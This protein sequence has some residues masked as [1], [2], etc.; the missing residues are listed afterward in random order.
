M[1]KKHWAIGFIISIL[2][3]GAAFWG[4]QPVRLMEVLEG[5]D[6][7]YLAPMTGLLF[8][9]L[10]TRTR[11][12]Q[13]LLNERVPYW[14]TFESLNEGY[15]LNMVL[16]LRMGELARAYLVT[17]ETNLH[18][19]W[20]TATVVLERIIDIIVC[21][22]GLLVVL[23]FVIQVDWAWNVVFSVAAG[24][25]IGIFVL[26]LLHRKQ[27]TLNDVLERI[28]FIR[29]LQ[30]SR[31]IDEFFSGLV[32]EDRI[33]RI[34]R[35]GLWSF[36]AWVT[37]WM[38][39]MLGLRMFQ[40]EGSLIVALF[41]SGVVAFGAA[42][43]SLPGAVGVFELSTVAGLLVFNYPQEAALSVAVVIHLHQLIITGIIGA[44]AL[45][46]EGETIAG[47]G[48]KLRMLAQIKA[49]SES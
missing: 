15:L 14:R 22:L 44:A 35:A 9:G 17:R 6:Y 37:S 21:L 13:I 4:V 3:L 7:L 8:L 19:G 33:K 47:L 2:A 34:L 1:K 38:T 31:M 23:P 45:S 10:A 41:V 12:W 36:L 26:Y 43:P 11:S 29:N 24:L 20:T 27:S 32:G 46:R 40:M 16:P 5:A 18:F 30:I 28:P 49:P 39:F 42:V 25:V 48:E